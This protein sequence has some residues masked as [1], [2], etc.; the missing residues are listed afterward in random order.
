[1][2]VAAGLRVIRMIDSGMRK[3]RRGV[4]VDAVGSLLGGACVVVN[5]WASCLRFFL[6]QVPCF[7]YGSCY[8]FR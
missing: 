5:I 6:S 2:V 7:S 3:G 4:R 8:R 1:M